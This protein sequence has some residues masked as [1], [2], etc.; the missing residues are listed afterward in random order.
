MEKIFDSTYARTDLEQV[1]A[2]A[3]QLNAE[4]RTQILRI[5]Q[6]YED[7]SDGTLGDWVTDIVNLE[8][9]TDSKPF[10][11]KYYMVPIINK[12]IFCN[13]LQ[14]LVKIELLTPARQSQ[15]GTPEFIIPNK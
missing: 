9:N 7:S 14:C 3:T 13:D 4:E 15:Y 2:N 8:I 5:L 6:N 12:E 1:A 10:N 11:F